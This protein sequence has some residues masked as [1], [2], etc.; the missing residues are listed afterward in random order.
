MSVHVHYKFMKFNTILYPVRNC[1]AVCACQAGKVRKEKVP[2]QFIV[3][4]V[5][6]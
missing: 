1:V 4:K 3:N 6:C 5:F 2:Y